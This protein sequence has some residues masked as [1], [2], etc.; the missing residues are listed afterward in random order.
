VAELLAKFKC[1]GEALAGKVALAEAH[2]GDAAE[3]ESVS[4][5]PGI[6]AVGFLGA[7]E[8]FAGVLQ[9][10]ASIASGEEDFGKS[11]AKFDRVPA[12]TAGVSQQDASISFLDRFGIVLEVELKFEGGLEAAELELDIACVVGEGARIL[13]M[14]GRL[15]VVIGDPEASE[16]GIAT[17]QCV[18]PVVPGRNL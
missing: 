18:T 14:L 8:S 17:A 11:D 15:S 5:A 12:E 4:F 10:L 16:Q 6:G 7:V 3:V 9:G 13:E 1:G 2:M